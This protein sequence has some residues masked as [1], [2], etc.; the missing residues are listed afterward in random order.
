[1]EL[2]KDKL[3]EL[4]G[5]TQRIIEAQQNDKIIIRIDRGK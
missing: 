1:M 3:E 5:A 4:I 2:K